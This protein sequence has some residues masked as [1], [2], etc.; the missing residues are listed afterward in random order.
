MANA[1]HAANVGPNGVPSSQTLE[2]G[3]MTRQNPARFAASLGR[4]VLL[5]AL[6][7]NALAAA[8]VPYD[9]RDEDESRRQPQL[10]VAHGAVAGA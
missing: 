1:R 3:Q 7:L 4:F 6:L 2:G 9:P 5:A 8:C 10:A